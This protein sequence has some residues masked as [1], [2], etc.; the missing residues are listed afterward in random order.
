MQAVEKATTLEEIISAYNQSPQDSNSRI[1]ALTKWNELSLQAVEK[2]STIEEAKS[3]YGLSSNTGDAQ[4]V[5]LERWNELS[6]KEIE[7]ANTLEEI[8]SLYKKAPYKELLGMV[9]VR[10]IATKK[11]I[12]FCTTVQAIK[13]LFY[14]NPYHSSYP[15]NM[16]IKWILEKWSELLL[17]E[18]ER[19]STIKEVKDVIGNIPK[20]GPFHE[21]L[22]PAIGRAHKRWGEL[23]TSY[24]ELRQY[25]TDCSPYSDEEISA[26]KRLI[27]L[28]TEVDQANELWHYRE[29]T[30]DI[31]FLK[32][33]ELSLLEVEKAM[34]LD[35]IFVADLRAP[36]G[37][38]A[39][40]VAMEKYLKLL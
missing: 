27:P 34:T 2:I 37:G 33:D 17:L 24:Q 8:I 38:R 11:G 16:Q 26:I 36:C 35:E 12:D 20:T 14:S 18:I 21:I 10:D 7:K 29:K 3:L 40:V 30:Q 15:E 6:F 9:N 28:C 32:W 4:K 39:K 22:Y 31:A 13:K 25:I 19:T 1:A 5:A 23:C